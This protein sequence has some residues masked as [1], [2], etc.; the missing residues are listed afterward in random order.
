MKLAYLWIAFLALSIVSLFVGVTDL[1]PWDL[2][3]MTEQQMQVMLVSRIPRLV[4]IWLAGIGM[5]VAG[6]LMQQLA[7]NKFVSPSTAGTTD[8]A[9]LGALLSIL[10]VPNAPPLMKIAIAFVFALIGTYAFMRILDRIQYREPILIA[11]I[12]LMFGSVI[13][14]VTTFLALKYDLLNSINSWLNGDFSVVLKGRYE[15]LYLSVPVIAIAY[16]FANRFTIAGMGEHFATNLGLHYRRVVSIGL[17]IVALVSSVVL[18]TIGSLP[19]LGLII[20]NLVSL[21]RGDDL[22]SSLPHT[23]LLGAV[24]VLGCDIIGRIAI[25][26][27]EIPIGLT[28]GVLGSAI[29]LYLLLRRPSYA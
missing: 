12:G 4:S 23:A 21:Y 8:A 9:S 24:F 27:Y 26:P 19:F 18:L 20:T 13:G 3:S 17:V 29:F 22:K 15:T 2:F 6:L 10:L 11:L 1:R 25:F 5:S 7:R 14:A 28:V 16:L